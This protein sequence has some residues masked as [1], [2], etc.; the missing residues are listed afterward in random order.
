MNGMIIP[1][2]GGEGL[3][4]FVNSIYIYMQTP[5]MYMHT[6]TSNTNIINN[7]SINGFHVGQS[8]C[9]VFVALTSQTKTPDKRGQ[10]GAM[11]KSTYLKFTPVIHLR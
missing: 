8:S 4:N 7:S 9:K 1:V 10:I 6:K 5:H 11:V 2:R 3:S